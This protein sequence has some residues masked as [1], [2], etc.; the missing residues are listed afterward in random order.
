MEIAFRVLKDRRMSNPVSSIFLLSDGQ[1]KKAE[2]AVQASMQAYLPSE[3]FKIHSF[4][5]G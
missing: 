1:D 5:F 3:C 4:G 2:N